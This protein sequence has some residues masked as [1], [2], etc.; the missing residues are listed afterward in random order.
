MP[1]EGRLRHADAL[2]GDA[3][4]P[5]SR[6]ESAIFN[7]APSAPIRWLSGNAQLSNISGS[8]RHLVPS[9][10]STFEIE[11]PRHIRGSDEGGNAALA[12]DGWLT[13][14]MITVPA[15]LPEVMNILEPLMT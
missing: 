15:I 6:P 7:P 10:S 2:R 13:T 8:V 14:K 9:L 12:G 1:V 4:R 3:I 5:A 11:K